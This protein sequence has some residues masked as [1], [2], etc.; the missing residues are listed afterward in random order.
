MKF[1]QQYKSNEQ[2]RPLHK[3]KLQTAKGKQI[4]G[5]QAEEEEQLYAKSLFLPNKVYDAE[6][7]E[8]VDDQMAK[9]IMQANNQE[10]NSRIDN[11]KATCQLQAADERLQSPPNHLSLDKPKEKSAI[12]SGS[13]QPITFFRKDIF[14]IYSKNYDPARL[15][16]IASKNEPKIF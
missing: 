4:A 7:L 1:S 14:K 15:V 6:F 5:I 9:L 12:S 13:S 10:M 2:I 16:Y 8:R 3:S 11:F